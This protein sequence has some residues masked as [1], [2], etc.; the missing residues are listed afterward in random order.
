MKISSE[1]P[2]LRLFNFA[3]DLKRKLLGHRGRKTTQ[4]EYNLDLLAFM[5]T[6]ICLP[7]LLV[8]QVLAWTMPIMAVAWPVYLFGVKGLMPFL[9]LGGWLVAAFMCMLTMTMLTDWI[10][11]RMDRRKLLKEGKDENH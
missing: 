6:L 2:V 3:D 9:V 7:F 5:R 11:E 4:I 1:S 10:S 8:I